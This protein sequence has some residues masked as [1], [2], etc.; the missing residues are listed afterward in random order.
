MYKNPK[1]KP[2]IVRFR[3]ANGNEWEESYT[4]RLVDIFKKDKNV[5]KII[6]ADTD[7]IMYKRE[8]IKK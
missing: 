6:D 3:T 4:T 1:F 2:I 7:E 5:I 8:E